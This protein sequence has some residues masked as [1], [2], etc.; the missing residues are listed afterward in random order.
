MVFRRSRRSSKKSK[1]NSLVTKSYL[2]KNYPKPELKLVGYTSTASLNL[3]TPMVYDLTEIRQGDQMNERIGSKVTP[4]NLNYSLFLKN[5]DVSAF[6]VRCFI[7]EHRDYSSPISIATPMYKSYTAGGSIVTNTFG[8]DELGLLDD[9]NPTYFRVLFDKTFF[10]G[11]DGRENSSFVR[12]NKWIKIRR[13][14]EWNLPGDL[15]PRLGRLSM[16]FQVYD[17]DGQ[18]IVTPGGINLG[19]RHTLSYYDV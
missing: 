11:A 14:I 3:L 1:G 17:A 2:R 6:F 4:K 5:T 15:Q 8:T 10:L 18:A 12:Y 16:C 7:V 9:I 13:E 19:L